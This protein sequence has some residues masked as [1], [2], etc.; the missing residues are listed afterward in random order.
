MSTRIRDSFNVQP[1]NLPILSSSNFVCGCEFEIESVK[2]HPEHPEIV[3]VEDHS[4]RNSGYEYKTRPNTYETTLT[5]FDYIHETISLGKDPFS[6]RTSIHVHVNML[7][8]PVATVRQ[9]VLAY[10]LLE[11]LF[12][13]FVG[14]EREHN[15]FCVPLSFTTMPNIYKKDIIYMHGQWHKYTAFN[16]LPLGQGKNSDQGL[17]TI[18]FRH[19]YG[20]ANKEVFQTWLTTLKEW[21]EWFQKYPEFNVTKEI[22]VGLTP[23][24]LA[25]LII[26]TL[27]SKHSV[28]QLNRLCQDSLL[29]VKLS[30]GGL[31][32]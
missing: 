32:K 12:F 6:H 17:G 5:L 1:S 16:I 31:A 30:V 28:L 11:P 29:D 23:A 21:Y 19:L 3:V 9:M 10:A 18:E 27:S 24:Q 7:N 20:T 4:L 26:P 8:M 22:E 25:G 15:I 14:Q 2:K 13:D